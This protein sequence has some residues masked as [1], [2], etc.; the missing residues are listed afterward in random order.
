MISGFFVS[1]RVTRDW[2]G[3]GGKIE[4][5]KRSWL[6]RSSFLASTRTGHS[7]LRGGG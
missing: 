5:K 2:G 4:G 1:K 7:P 6:F 3:I